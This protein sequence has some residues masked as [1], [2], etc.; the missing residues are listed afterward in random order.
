MDQT[1]PPPQ[2]RWDERGKKP[3]NLKVVLKIKPPK[4][5]KGVKKLVRTPGRWMM[6]LAAETTLR[7]RGDAAKTG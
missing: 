2:G 3:G 7:R 5:R 4:F 6:E 1:E